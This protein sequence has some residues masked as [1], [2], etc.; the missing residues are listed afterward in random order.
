MP[1]TQSPVANP[2]NGDG[3]A[4]SSDPRSGSLTPNVPLAFLVGWVA[5]VPRTGTQV[6]CVL[7]CFSLLTAELADADT[8]LGKR[9]K[10]PD[11]RLPA[12]SQVPTLSSGG[13]SPCG[14]Q[15]GVPCP[16]F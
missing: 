2:P 14:L 15:V 9:P 11:D 10:F 1:R 8:P 3:G 7:V 6:L 12:S 5:D 13:R 16:G 4:A